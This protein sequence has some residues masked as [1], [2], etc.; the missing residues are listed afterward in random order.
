[1]TEFITYMVSVVLF[2]AVVMHIVTLQANHHV[3]MH[4]M[5][6]RL[7]LFPYVVAYIPHDLISNAHHQKE[8]KCTYIALT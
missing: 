8:N 2:R 7:N 4:Q 5:S 6:S 3:K 1:M